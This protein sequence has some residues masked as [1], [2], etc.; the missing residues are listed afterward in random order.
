MKK[1]NTERKMAK[2][3]QKGPLQELG[4]SAG[5]EKVYTLLLK[6]G[7]AL[8]ADIAKEAV[9][10]R[11]D[12]YR[13]IKE[14]KTYNLVMEVLYGKRKK[15]QAVSPESI[16]SILKQKE[17]TV[18]E[19][20]SDLLK[21]F[22]T[23]VT[24]GALQTEAFAGKEGLMEL[25]RVLVRDAKKKAELYRIESPSDYRIIKKYYP[26]EYW[27]RSSSRVGIGDL[28]KYVI[29]NEQTGAA[30][31]KSINRST[32][33][34]PTGKVP[35]NQDFTTIIIEDKVAYLDFAHERGLLIR[36]TRFADYM[37]SVFWI[38]YNAL[39]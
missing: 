6:T 10:F 19:G 12:T 4:V 31:R 39:P 17:N 37:K 25:Y 33:S 11:P 20:V 2:T 9:Q 8:L 1:K 30:R 36:D 7:P 15:Y 28:V 38:M 3:G 13:F 24:D 29:T 23:R 35:F 22:D 14:L 26:K 34:I 32:K 16:Y 5:A 27:H 18:V 21:V